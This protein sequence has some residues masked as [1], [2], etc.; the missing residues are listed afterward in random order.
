LET[1]RVTGPYLLD[2]IPR[3]RADRVEIYCHPAMASPG[4]P[5][6]GTPGSGPAE[7]SALLCPRVREAIGRSG[8]V[9]SK[10]GVCASN[11]GGRPCGPPNAL[12]STAQTPASHG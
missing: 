7:L 9:L 12:A 1:G 6:N 2:L 4:E 8:F 10:P 11:L 3:I 5:S